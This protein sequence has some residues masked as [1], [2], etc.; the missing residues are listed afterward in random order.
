MADEG[1]FPVLLPGT[2]YCVRRGPLS[3]GKSS[4]G[5]C[6]GTTRRYCGNVSCSCG[7]QSGP[8][9]P[10]SPHIRTSASFVSDQH[11]PCKRTTLFSGL[12]ADH[13]MR[14]FRFGF[15]DRPNGFKPI[16]PHMLVT[17]G[18]PSGFHVL[19][20]QRTV[21]LGRLQVAPHLRVTKT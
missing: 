7:S 16:L 20:L 19:S 4:E 18:M 5:F 11:G 12:G 15:I 6:L 8:A 10:L 14:V 2:T 3:K 21:G 13:N 9:F 1:K 17:S